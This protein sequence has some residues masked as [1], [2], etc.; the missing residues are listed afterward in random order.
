MRPSYSKLFV[1][2][3]V[4]CACLGIGLGVAILVGGAHRFSGPSFVGPRDLVEPWLPWPAYWA[5]GTL[6]ASYGLWVV[7]ALGRRHAVHT[8]RFGVVVYLFLV[9]SFARS[10]GMDV[11]ASLTGVVAYSAIA[12]LHLLLSD[13]LAH[14]GWE[15]C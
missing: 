10:V 11:R 1:R 4:L 9:L 6:F 15:R 5:W 14:R 3:Y 8:L 13:H 7:F 12:V 2:L